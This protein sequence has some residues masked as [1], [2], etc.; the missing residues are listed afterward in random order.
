[1]TIRN[2][3]AKKEKTFGQKVLYG[4][5]TGVKVAGL[6]AGT[7]L[8]AAAE[9]NHRTDVNNMLASMSGEESRAAHEFVPNRKNRDAKIEIRSWLGSTRVLPSWSNR[10]ITYKSSSEAHE[11][12]RKISKCIQEMKQITIPVVI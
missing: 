3:F 5:T 6:V 7:V 9:E 11:G 10:P 2:P 1:M 8:V 12:A 4:V